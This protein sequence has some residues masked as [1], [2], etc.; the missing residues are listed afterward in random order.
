MSEERRR[1]RFV[2]PLR[3]RTPDHE[4]SGEIAFLPMDAIGDDG[5]FDNDQTRDAAEIDGQGYTYFREG[6]V[7]RARVTPCFENGKGAW[8]RTLL[9]GEG[10]G[11]TELFV[12]KP[13]PDVDPRYLYYVQAGS[14]FTQSGAATMY[15]A[16]GVKR[17]TDEFARDYRVWLPPLS[18]QRTIADYLDR[19]TTR[20]DQV[21]A[22]KKKM[23]QA[24]RA[25]WQ[26]VMQHAVSGDL[27]AHGR[28]R[29][30]SVAWL[31][32]MPNHWRDAQVKL[33]ARLGSGHTPSRSHPEWWVNPTIPW[34]TTG[35]VA[36]LRNDDVEYITDTREKIS[37]VGM[38]NSAAT[39]HPAH[40]VVLCRTAS[41]GYSGIMATPMATSQDFATWTCGPLLRPRFLLLCLRAMRHDLLGRLA[42]GS[43]HKTIYMPD[44][45]GIKIPLPPVEE[46]D[47]I[48][49]AAY[50][51]HFPMKRAMEVLDS[52]IHLLRERKDALITGAV[53]GELMP[54]TA[55]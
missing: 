6:D 54:A 16:H 21:V 41:A 55:A 39:L 4:L 29:H 22:G 5:S 34:I 53:T 49:S 18:E 31:T 24:L 51:Q 30:S 14:E 13:G 47:E 45:E 17:V 44:L 38:A 25:R 52:Q 10:L 23:L 36:A 7:V 11:T 1:M 3:S 40:T 48:V 27:T 15:G 33:V 32:C 2:A 26:L 37:E 9:G 19:E 20:I 35:E 43:T 50:R 12:F 46:Q 8:L 42:M 28:R